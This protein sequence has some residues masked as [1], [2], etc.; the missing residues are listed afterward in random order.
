MLQMR[1]F[2][3]HGT[4]LYVDPTTGELRHGLPAISPANAKIVLHGPNAQIVHTTAGTLETITCSIDCS[5]SISQA[6]EKGG[7]QH[8][9]FSKSCNLGEGRSHSTRKACFSQPRKMGALLFLG[10]NAKHGRALRFA[11]RARL[12]Q[13]RLPHLLRRTTIQHFF[14]SGCGTAPKLHGA[15]YLISRMPN[16]HCLARQSRVRSR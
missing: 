3:T 6:K 4:V 12:N 13:R 15:V 11:K 16:L 9:L 7:R 1:V 5:Q 2:T 8:L 14:Q 10:R